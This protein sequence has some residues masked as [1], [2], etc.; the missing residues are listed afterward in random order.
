MKAA[1]LLSLQLGLPGE[2]QLCS[3]NLLLCLVSSY[4]SAAYSGQGQALLCIGFLD[5]GPPFRN[6]CQ[7]S[8][9]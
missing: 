3:V 9:P 1:L 5:A 4:G 8:L 7:A 6:S 2:V